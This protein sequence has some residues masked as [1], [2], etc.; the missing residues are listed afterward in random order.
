MNKMNLFL[1]LLIVGFFSGCTSMQERLAKH[2][3]CT[4]D[5]ANVVRNMSVP[6][7]E[8]YSVT[9]KQVEYSCKLTPFSEVCNPADK[10]AAAPA[11]AEPVKT[12]TPV[13]TKA[14][15]KK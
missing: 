4:K 1:A 2:V 13:K 15:P 7:Y 14:K 12:A 6:G 8:E 9:C 10:P 3:G 5:E 11:A